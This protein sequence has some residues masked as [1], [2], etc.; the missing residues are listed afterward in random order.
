MPSHIPEAERF[1]TVKADHELSRISPGDV[2][3]HQILVEAGT[4]VEVVT[5]AP[6]WRRV[7]LLTGDD[8]G[9]T[10][11]VYPDEVEPAEAPEEKGLQLSN[12]PGV[13]LT[14]P[15]DGRLE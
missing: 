15:R 3:S 12:G 4:T 8:K 11:I 7:A 2:A 9:F 1:V 10:F 13:P 6:T 14:G 5:H